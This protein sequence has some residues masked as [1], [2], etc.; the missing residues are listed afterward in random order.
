MNTAASSEDNRSIRTIL[1]QD[2]G[3]VC[4][5]AGNGPAK[6]LYDRATGE[7]LGFFTASRACA[8]IERLRAGEAR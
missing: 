8:L 6:A 2:H 7:R 1:Y 5:P 3:I 4:S